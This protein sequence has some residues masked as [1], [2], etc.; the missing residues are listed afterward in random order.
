MTSL[1]RTN[2]PFIEQQCNDRPAVEGQAVEGK[3]IFLHAGQA[4]ASKKP[5]CVVTV[6]S[7]SV[8]VCLVAPI[9]KIGGMTHFQL[10]GASWQ[11]R[12]NPGGGYLAITDLVQGMRGLSASEINLTALIFGGSR[13][14][15]RAARSGSSGSVQDLGQRNVRMA[16]RLLE[17]L[18]IPVVHRDVGGEQARKIHFFTGT[19]QYLVDTIAGA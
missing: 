9:E 12:K 17:E 1:D 18:G 14:S 16:E 8:G 15:S 13:L 4:Y 3:K 7:S 11:K 19:G 10:P 5:A 6:L 2:E